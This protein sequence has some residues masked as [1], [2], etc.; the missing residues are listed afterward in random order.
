LGRDLRESQLLNRW[1]RSDANAFV[2]NIVLGK[3]KKERM[4]K[5]FNLGDGIGLLLG[6]G[7]SMGNE[8]IKGEKRENRR[9]SAKLHNRREGHAGSGK[10]KLFFFQ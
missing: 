5:R 10:T 7:D 1:L 2:Q 6:T 4:T 8:N 3:K 9:K